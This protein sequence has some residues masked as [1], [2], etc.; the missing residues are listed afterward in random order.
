MKYVKLNEKIE[1][2]CDPFG[3]SPVDIVWL[4]RQPSSSDL[5]SSAAASNQAA[6]I[7]QLNHN[8]AT[9]Q[10]SP[11]SLQ[12]LALSNQSSST[13]TFNPES[14]G[15]RLF[16]GTIRTEL[17]HNSRQSD[18]SATSNG[19]MTSKS[20]SLPT[21]NQLSSGEAFF[22]R[23]LPPGDHLE[24]FAS[25]EILKRPA[26]G[27]EFVRLYIRQARRAHS[28]DLICQARN[29]YG[30]DEKLIKL[31]VQEAPDPVREITAVQ[32][33]SRAAVLTWL[34][35]YNGN[36]PITSYTVEWAQVA[37]QNQQQHHQQQQQ[38][39]QHQL[40]GKWSHMITQQPSATITS[41]VSMTSYEI[42]IRARN[43][44]GQSAF[45]T[46][47]G[48]S[49]FIVTT[50]E[51]APAAPPSDLRAIPLSSSSIQ[52]SWVAPGDSSMNNELRA[53]T[54]VKSS[55]GSSN[56]PS[57][58]IRGYYLGY[59]ATNTNDSFVFKTVSLPEGSPQT[60]DESDHL[61]ATSELASNETSIDQR[62][63]LKSSPV[64]TG[65]RLKVIIDNLRRST[66]YVII[67][68][69]FNSAG[70]GPQSD[71][72]ESKTLANDPPPAPLLRV[73]LVTYSSIEL[74]WSFQ[75]TPSGGSELSTLHGAQAKLETIG[76][77]ES[78]KPLDTSS[79]KD[80]SAV[81]G[82]NVYYRALEGQWAEQKLTPETHAIIASG[83]QRS[84]LSI[85]ELS[86]EKISTTTSPVETS[87]QSL[88]G[89][90]RDSSHVASKSFR[91]ILDQLA[92]GN[93]YQIYLV[94]YN[95]IGSGLPSQIIRAKTRGSAPIAPRRQDY[96]SVNSTYVQL[97]FEAWMDGGCS[98]TNFEIK[99]KPLSRSSAVSSQPAT[100]SG[101]GSSSSSNNNGQ[102]QW[103]LLSS[104]VSPEQRLIELR[105]LQPETWYAVLTKAESAA[106][107]TEVQ[108]S[109]MTLNKWGQL[110]AE[111][112]EANNLPALFGQSNASIRSI[113]YNFLPTG[114]MSTLT[115]SAC[116]CLVLFATCL[117]FAVRRYGG[118]LK[119]S[120]SLDSQASTSGSGSQYQ[121][122]HHHHHTHPHKGSNHLNGR[123]RQQSDYEQQVIGGGMATKLGEE[124]PMIY[125]ASNE[126]TAELYSLKGSPCKTTTSATMLTATDGSSSGNCEGVGLLSTTQCSNGADMSGAMP[127]L[128]VDLNQFMNP[129]RLVQGD[130]HQCIHPSAQF[131]SSTLGHSSQ[132]RDGYRCSSG[133][134]E[135][136]IVSPGRAIVGALMREN[137]TSDHPN[138][139]KTIACRPLSSF[140]TSSN[141]QNNLV[142]TSR[143]IC[144]G[145]GQP[146]QQLNL[147][148]YQHHLNDQQQIYSKLRL[149]Y[150]THSN[151]NLC[152][153]EENPKSSQTILETND[154]ICN[155][156][157]MNL[158]VL[159][160]E[161]NQQKLLSRTLMRGNQQQ[162]KNIYVHNGE[163]IE[164]VGLDGNSVDLS[165]LNCQ[166]QQDTSN[167]KSNY[168]QFQVNQQIADANACGNNGLTMSNGYNANYC[169]PSVASG[170]TSTNTS[171]SQPTSSNSI[172]HNSN[173]AD[174]QANLISLANGDNATMNLSIAAGAPCQKAKVCPASQMQQSISAAQPGPQ[175]NEP[176]D[177]A[178]PFPPKW[179]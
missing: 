97:N 84:D 109:F 14:L 52:L 31:L 178:Q 131:Q 106:G 7:S 142:P 126:Q 56:Q 130:H 47:V 18:P 87:K 164:Q 69:A 102:N 73:G 168:G 49:P 136:P 119:D 37:A 148:D 93:S 35:P 25:F 44:F 75:T 141:I 147:Q 1:L 70:P 135:S 133:C 85:V 15:R 58:S 82:Y 62:P 57:Y 173:N 61:L 129:N 33:D 43:Q 112:M 16:I 174:Q 20:P 89:W 72:I 124:Q 171:S 103:L 21:D 8:N 123:H 48:S 100:E 113:L 71:Q 90:H 91:F 149:I 121:H 9:F 166:Q 66:K 111:A 79:E 139:F 50:A 159:A 95:S 29:R 51:E 128:S 144:N 23:Q 92:C 116:M 42:R 150:N 162:P 177:Y 68:Q 28:A 41:L 76:A 32:V 140:A 134:A 27:S 99:Y 78:A 40:T 122:H 17:S 155:G 24:P 98:I 77:N 22:G 96:I 81:D 88:H 53:A 110:P 34:A 151:Y 6:A 176:N 105:D 153:I 118:Q 170:S 67:V 137:F 86:S 179:V 125:R 117:L 114:H 108:Y 39:Q 154:Q 83:H 94:A 3:Q 2:D 60:S 80:I 104:N 161:Q 36:S 26:D 74:Q 30:G 138:R 115:M 160:Q 107:K 45:A 64:S 13:P 54:A 175:N 63:L 132:H 55:G 10:A 127:E 19:P 163:Y 156:D 65:R 11:A 145:N 157:T 143:F 158:A 146:E 4:V 101:S 46:S 172:S 59:K 120:A 12:N 38:Q 169:A 5:S 152:G 165:S 167:N